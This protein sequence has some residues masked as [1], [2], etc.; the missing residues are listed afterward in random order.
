MKE[1]KEGEGYKIERIMEKAPVKHNR[2]RRMEKHDY[3]SACIYLITV[4]TEGRKRILG[5]LVGDSANTAEIEP[6]ALGK[7]VAEAFRKII[8]WVRLLLLGKAIV[9]MFYGKSLRYVLRTLVLRL[10]L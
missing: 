7:Y 1:M 6:T 5:S 3:T 4:T 8:L 2:L 10:W 9:P